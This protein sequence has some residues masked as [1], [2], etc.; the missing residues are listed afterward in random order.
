MYWRTNCL[1]SWSFSPRP[2]PCVLPIWLIEFKPFRVCD[3]PC[4]LFRLCL[5]ISSIHFISRST[6]SIVEVKRSVQ[7]I[8]TR[9]QVVKLV[10]WSCYPFPVSRWPPCVTKKVLVEKMEAVHKSNQEVLQKLQQAAGTTTTVAP[11]VAKIQEA[12]LVKVGRKT[13]SSRRNS[14]GQRAEVEALQE[15][16]ELQMVN[17][18][19][20]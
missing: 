14:M 16:S 7:G 17:S 1:L 19:P 9:K 10:V 6:A 5:S 15:K 3:N 2:L 20:M 11:P 4:Y 12:G 13:P 18:S 8:Q